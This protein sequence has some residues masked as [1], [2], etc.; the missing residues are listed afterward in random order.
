VGKGEE[1]EETRTC[2]ESRGLTLRLAQS[3]GELRRLLRSS[4]ANRVRRSA[5]ENGCMC[6]ALIR[7]HARAFIT[8]AAARCHGARLLPRSVQWILNV[9]RRE[10][11][12]G[13]PIFKYL[14]IVRSH[15]LACVR[16][17]RLFISPESHPTLLQ[18]ASRSLTCLGRCEKFKR[19]RRH[20][21]FA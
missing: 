9:E 10:R 11:G 7:E 3:S 13:H 8:R 2:G 18:R 20:S 5:N 21:C 6:F 14:R 4:F 17:R 16:S 1:E 15:A 19:A 12:R